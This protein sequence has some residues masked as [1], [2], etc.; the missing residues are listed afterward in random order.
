MKRKRVFD[1]RAIIKRT[2]EALEKSDRFIGSHA[3]RVAREIRESF[4]KK[5]ELAKEERRRRRA[6]KIADNRAKRALEN[7]E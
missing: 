5:D 2:R 3:A 4:H 7:E 6:L 1:W